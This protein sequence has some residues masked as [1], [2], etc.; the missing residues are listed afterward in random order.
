MYRNLTGYLRAIAKRGL[1]LFAIV[2]SLMI[3]TSRSQDINRSAS[4][5]DAFD[6][7]L[8]NLFPF[9]DPTGAVETYTTDPSGKV[10]LTG[11]FFQ[12]LG[13]NGRTCATCHQPSDAWT[14][15]AAHVKARF[16][17]SAGKD[18][19]FRTVD[20]S[21]CDQ[22]IDVSTLKGREKA[23]SL[24]TT[25][26]L[27]RIAVAVPVSAQ[28]EVVGVNNPYGCNDMSTLSM[29]RRPLPAANLRFLSTVMFDG[30][31]SATQTGTQK[32]TFATNPGDLL[33]DLAHQ[34][35]DAT[36]GHA[37]ASSDPTPAQQQ[38]IVNFEMGLSVAQAFDFRAGY[39]NGAGVNGGPLPLSA[40]PF[41]VGTNDSFP[42]SFGFNP[43]GAPFTPTIFT[44][45]D[46]WLSYEGRKASI[47]RGEQIFNSKLINIA[48]VAGVNDVLGISVLPG[49][50]GTCHDLPNVGNHS[51]PAPLN[52][53]TGDLNSP[54]DV[55]YLPVFTLRN[56][57]TGAVV[58]TTD[59]GRAL[60]TGS[61]ADVGKVKGP[62]LRGL[63]ARAPYFHNGSANTLT[64]VVNFYDKRFGIGFTDQEKADL[65]AFLSSL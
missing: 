28:F 50:C 61:W 39:L 40:Q 20:G 57:S 53:G 34:A 27:I 15:S 36:R 23:Y 12:S 9:V 33:F 32:I 25:R 46:H 6:L 51:F 16:L 62:I 58:E 5:G 35:V 56:R 47:A 11:P 24:L 26:G 48:D 7:R 1:L 29:Y 13:T 44:L 41:F 54:L 2:C 30:R 60:I 42:A 45:F 8:P 37:Q 21:N 64:D 3:G 18:P 10:D 17:L 43:T 65:V 19:I 52:I 4:P 49:T 14:V 22:N 63:S 55:S 59:P 31:E 38:A